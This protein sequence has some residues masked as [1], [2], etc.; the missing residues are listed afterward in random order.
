MSAGGHRLPAA[1]LAPVLQVTEQGFDVGVDAGQRPFNVELP[2]CP[3]GG[4]DGLAAVHRQDL[5]ER[6]AAGL[7]SSWA[8]RMAACS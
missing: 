8:I 3:G 4:H 1:A 6:D 5:H 7:W 2:Q